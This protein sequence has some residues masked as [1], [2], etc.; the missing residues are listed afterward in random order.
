MCGILVST[1]T[2]KDS[3]FKHET[4]IPRGP[5]QCLTKTSN[6][7]TF[8]FHRL[9]IMDESEKGMQPFVFK[10]NILVANAEIYNYKAIKES[11]SH[12]PFAS[13]SDCEV[14]LPLYEEMGLD[15]FSFLDAEFAIVLYYK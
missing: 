2:S 8:I 4:L 15:M 1:S 13:E 9:A 11:L 10:G 5:D 7:I 3:L 12:I 6:G 14:L